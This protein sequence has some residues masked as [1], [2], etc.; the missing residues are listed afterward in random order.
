[1]LVVEKRNHIAGNC[2]DEKSE[3]GI[4]IHKYGPHIFHTNNKPVWDFVNRFTKMNHFQHKVLSYTEGNLITFPINRDTICQIFGVDIPVSDVKGFLNA[5]VAKASFNVPHENFRDAVVSQVGEKLY[6]LFFKNYTIKQWEKQPE[7]LS[8]E[9]AS[10]IPV[11]DNRDP[12]YF[13][14]KYQGVPTNGYTD[15][16]RNMLDHE[17]ISVLYN[18]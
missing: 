15:M 12:R 3:C 16:I 8:P 18:T 13:S 10:R 9:I 1:M 14:D 17:N 5:E 4:T 2:Y 7:E 11:R 6:E